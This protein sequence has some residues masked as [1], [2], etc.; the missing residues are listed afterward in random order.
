MIRKFIFHF[1]SSS[2]KFAEICWWWYSA[3]IR[4]MD[5]VFGQFDHD[6]SH[7][8]S[9]YFPS[10]CW[11]RCC[12]NEGHHSR[13]CDQRIPFIPN[14]GC[15]SSW[16]SFRPCFR[17]W[18]WEGGKT[19]TELQ[20]N[21][22][23]LSPT[24]LLSLPLYLSASQSWSHSIL[25]NYRMPIRLIFPNTQKTDFTTTCTFLWYLSDLIISTYFIFRVLSFTLQVSSQINYS[26][27]SDLSQYHRMST[28]HVFKSWSPSRLLLVYLQVS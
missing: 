26:N 23:L 15:K 16:G 8:C 10:S 22:F 24:L 5:I 13:S 9:I 21:P 4:G 1:F 25:C 2:H 17:T 3:T 12:R 20:F 18:C 6:S 19:Y 14:S 28:N 27:Y 11:S 7:P